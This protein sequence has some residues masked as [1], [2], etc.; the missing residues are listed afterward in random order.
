MAKRLISEERTPEF[1]SWD[2]INTGGLL[3]ITEKCKKLDLRVAAGHKNSVLN[4]P[5][6]WLPIQTT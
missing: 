5:F 4:R 2:R 1:V 6:L 3:K